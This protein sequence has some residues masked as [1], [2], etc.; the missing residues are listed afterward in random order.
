[1]QFH[2]SYIYIIKPIFDLMVRVRP[3]YRKGKSGLKAARIMI[4]MI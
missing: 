4:I 1:M 3:Y 2:V